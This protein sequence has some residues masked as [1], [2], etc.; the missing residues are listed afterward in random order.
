VA[1]GI[2]PS[3]D[4][5]ADDAIARALGL[6]A[7]RDGVFT[8]Q[9]TSPRK[10]RPMQLFSWLHKRM[11]DRLPMRR[12]PVHKPF[13]RFRPRLEALESRDLPSF[14]APIAYSSPAPPTV[15]LIT[16][17]MN[18]D[19]KSD[20][21]SADNYDQMIT[22]RLT[23]ASGAIGNGDDHFDGPSTV[24]SNALAVGPYLGQPTIWVASFNPIT[25]GTGGFIV[26]SL[27]QRNTTGTL[28]D[29][30]GWSSTFISYPYGTID[31]MTMAQLSSTGQMGLVM[32]AE[33]GIFVVP[34][35]NSTK[36]RSEGGIGPLQS[37]SVPAG[38][39]APAQLAVGDFNGDGEPDIVVT[40]ARYNQG[41]V[42]VLLNN[43]NGTFGGYRPYAVGG[44]PGGVAIGDVN[45]DGKLDIVTANANGTVSVLPGLGNGTF[46]AAQ[47]YTVGGA[48]NSVV[49]GDLTHDGHLDIATTGSTEMDLLMNN[50]DGTF[51]AYQKIGPAG[52]ALL[53][54]D[55]NGDGFLDLA[56]IDASKSSIDIVMNNPNSI[57]TPLALSFGGLYWDS[58]T[59]QY[60][61]TLTL[62]NITSDTLT[63]PLS[64]EVMNLPSSA[65]LTD[66]TGTTNG[67]PYI[68]FL[69]SGQTLTQGASV[70]ITLTFTA[71]NP[72]DPYDITFNP[73]VAVLSF[74]VTGFPASTT[75]GVAQTFTVTALNADGTVDTGYS[76]TV[77]FT[78]TD[79]RAVLP[80]NTTLTH[81]TGTFVA[82]L[83]TAGLQ[84]IT[85]TDTTT[86][87][88]T[89]YE[90]LIS[91]TPAAASQFVLS[92]PSIVTL[93][94]A[95]SV[96]LTVEDAYGNVVT[97]YTGTVHFT[98]SDGTASL[99]ADY[100]FSAAD[101]GVHTFTGLVLHKKGK[102]QT[103]T[104]TDT[105]D[106]SL[107]ATDS[108][109]VS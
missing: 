65:V 72:Y 30:Q 14:S 105:L 68:Q 43:G 19:G 80:A 83:E 28:T 3:R 7:G 82:T 108:I 15:A 109:S 31:S 75:A 64:L 93:G 22:L 4:A 98:S 60:T 73:E 69:S 24:H 79:P 13:H 52:S 71:A 88:M 89:G 58:Q 90:A 59:S 2:P 25:P 99:P 76:G 6:R 78:S 32:A 107:T 9:Q 102:Q 77:H 27:L 11:T 66:A 62:T 96:T 67:T 26:M 50:G 92:A 33:G 91:V 97:G 8:I 42:L 86:G 18:G 81:G 37:Y 5:P 70:T 100:T 101:G 74:A 10:E 39:F 63:G 38:G 104:V 53:A 84:S 95:F 21:V 34:I 48:A 47:N 17:D 56:Q 54:A 35:S 61:W 1:A 29:V 12:T 57:P 87:A 51:A 106:S 46:G 41:Q 45:G 36:G 49:L 23:S 40:S 16:G 55:F 44:E 20:L 85:A 103:L 94:A